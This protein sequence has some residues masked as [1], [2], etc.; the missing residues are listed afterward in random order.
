VKNANWQNPS[1]A[2]VA[3]H[4]KAVGEDGVGLFNADAMATQAD[5]RQHLHQ[6]DDAGLRLAKGLDSAGRESLM[7]AIELNAV[8]V[9]NNKT[10]FEWGR[11]AAHDCARSSAA[12]AGTQVIEFKKR[13]TLETLVAR[14]VEFLTAYQNAAYA[15]NTSV[16]RQG[17]RGGSAAGPRC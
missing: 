13:E 15:R 6:P 5:G 16:C 1:E 4:G 11:Q 3:E 8:A 10:A 9:E 14:R 7:R 17:A 12:G 2:C